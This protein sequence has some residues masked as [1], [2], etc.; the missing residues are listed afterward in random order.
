MMKNA[1]ILILVMSFILGLFFKL[2]GVASAA[3]MPPEIAVNDETREC[4][5][6]MRGDECMNCYLPEG[7][8]ILGLYPDVGCPQGYEMIYLDL[9]CVTDYGCRL[10]TGQDDISTAFPRL[11]LIGIIAGAGCCG[12]VG[13]I[14]IVV[15]IVW[16]LNRGKKAA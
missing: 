9:D 1:R 14:I 15:L 6:V 5:E 16:M 11:T 10:K 2:V 4:A 8:E 13:V 12:L 3:P 7:W